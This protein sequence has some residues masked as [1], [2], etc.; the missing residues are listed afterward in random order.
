[1]SLAEFFSHPL[2]AF[3]IGLALGLWVAVNCWIWRWSV[4]YRA[5]VKY[6]L[7][8]IEPLRI[9]LAAVMGEIP[10]HRVTEEMRLRMQA[11][12]GSEPDEGKETR[13]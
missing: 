11:A 9:E 6:C 8:A 5:G 10:V 7:E 1:M 13:H 2:Y 4:G 12:M 3:L